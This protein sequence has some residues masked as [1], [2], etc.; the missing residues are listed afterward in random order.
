MKFIRNLFIV[1]ILA[2]LACGGTV[3][4]YYSNEYRYSYTDISINEPAIYS[5]DNEDL[6]D[7]FKRV[8]KISTEEVN[9]A[10]VNF[11]EPQFYVITHINGKNQRTYDIYVTSVMTRTAYIHD[12]KTDILYKM[13]P[14]AFV[15]FFSR[16][17]VANLSYKFTEP[18]EMTLTAN[19]LELSAKASVCDW[20][21]IIADGSYVKVSEVPDGG[22]VFGAIQ[23]GSEDFKISLPYNAT[24]LKAKVYTE[25]GETLFAGDVHDGLLPCVKEDG[26][27]YYE[28]T[29]VWNVNI[30]KDFYGTA[31]YVFAIENDVPVTINAEKVSCYQG[32]FLRLFAKNANENDVYS[33]SCPDLR[34]ESTFFTTENGII[35][36]LPIP[37]DATPGIHSLVLNENG[38]TRTIEI[39]VKEQSFDRGT[40]TI[41]IARPP[42]AEEE[43]EAMISPFRTSISEYQYTGGTFSIPVEGKI[44]TSFGLHR[45]TNGSDTYTIHNGQDIA[46]RGNPDIKAAKDGVV[47]FV[48]ELQITGKTIVIDHGMNILSYY[49]H[50][51]K[52]NVEEGQIVSTGEKIGVMGT[53]GY[54]TGDHLHYTVMI[55]GVATNPVTLYDVD[56]SAEEIK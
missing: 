4:F 30:S 50:M 47:V 9:L 1:L 14:S 35:S 53:T 52:T 32:E 28:V 17:E 46:A 44:T 11:R 41:S 45:Y 10:T 24:S 18:C 8:M 36:L 6:S 39:E 43:L 12:K 23:N 51:K 29:A 20:N 42:E 25:D 19:G 49:Y 26:V 22:E 3:L 48:G 27:V 40:L 15:V 38:V 5:K 31:K 54:S 55:N 34:Y 13:N 56:P 7:I 21:Y 16:D 33:V 37:C 2:A